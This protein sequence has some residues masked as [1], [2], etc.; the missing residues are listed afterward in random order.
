MTKND[1]EGQ[2]RSDQTPRLS[3]NIR[4]ILPSELQCKFSAPIVIENRSFAGDQNLE[5]L[6]LDRS[7]HFRNCIFQGTLHM[8]SSNIAGLTFENCQTKRVDISYATIGN[9]LRFLHCT[10]GD[11][12][13]V[14]IDAKGSR[15]EKGISAGNSKNTNPTIFH[16]TVNFSHS[17]IEG[18]FDLSKCTIE[19]CQKQFPSGRKELLALSLVRSHCKGVNLRGATITGQVRGIGL[20][21]DGQINLCELSLSNPGKDALVLERCASSSSILAERAKIEGAVSLMG[22][23]IKG[24]IS[25]SASSITTDPS[26]K[27]LDLSSLSCASV[28]LQ[29]S[30]EESIASTSTNRH[31][32]HVKVSGRVD[33]SSSAISLDLK[34]VDSEIDAY[35]IA[36]GLDGSKIGGRILA[37]NTKISSLSPYEPCPDK[38][39]AITARRVSVGRD[40]N[41]KDSSFLGGILLKNIRI[42]SYLSFESCKFKLR[43][44]ELSLRGSKIGTDLT[45]NDSHFDGNGECNLNGAQV[46]GT[47]SWTNIKGEV[48]V[49]LDSAFAHEIDDD[50]K[51]WESVK[52]LHLEGFNFNQFGKSDFSQIECT[53]RI[54]WANQSD[55]SSL[56]P[57][58]ALAKFYSQSS[59]PE[60]ER[61][62][63]LECHKRQVESIGPIGRRVFSKA[64]LILTGHGYRLHGLVGFSIFIIVAGS[65]L[66]IFAK[67]FDFVNP[68][69]EGLSSISSSSANQLSLESSTYPSP[70]KQSVE[71]T[72][73]PNLNPRVCTDEYHC[74]APILWG[75]DIVIP[76]SDLTQERY[77]IPDRSKSLGWIFDG[78]TASL[79][80]L[81]WL[82]LTVLIGEIIRRFQ[83]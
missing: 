36:L 37:T 5:F 62:V 31:Q 52:R 72:V 76:A 78:V 11:G 65:A 58:M 19:P 77:W 35:G 14:A 82:A 48:S 55:P 6:H 16:G 22:A 24:N 68:T 7:L 63:M 21:S 10:I 80:G 27:A 8:Q 51:S 73:P 81:G 39:E 47:F 12:A 53:E 79:K 56:S 18:P 29:N 60:R 46:S 13:G 66:G 38:N 1:E 45:F 41:F 54:E 9:Q 42:E 43:D 50:R 67:H 25:F 70:E 40:F 23:D 61:E 75:L 57:L 71:P 64:M 44:S 17:Q 30:S 20:T 26:H 33:I 15:I 32:N 69:P 49:D 83:R 34:L 74:F 3:E 2:N 28:L 4:D 59:H